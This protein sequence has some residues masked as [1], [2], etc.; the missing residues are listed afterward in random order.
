MIS[1]S[2]LYT[3]AL[4]LGTMSMAF[5]VGYHYLEVTA[6]QEPG[7]EPEPESLAAD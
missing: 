2:D 5:I 1:D 4:C 3:I 7:P 6:E